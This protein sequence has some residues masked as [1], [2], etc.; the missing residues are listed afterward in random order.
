M[1]ESSLQVDTL[2]FFNGILAINISLSGDHHAHVPSPRPVI[3][4]KTMAWSDLLAY[5]RT[6]SSL[7]TFHEK[8]PEDLEDPNG[9]IAMRFLKSLKELVS[10]Q[11]GAVEDSDKIDVEWPLALILAKK[12]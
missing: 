10:R 4:R 5:F 2:V 6:F 7:H 8:H 11:G 3:L 1:N 12:V 9:D